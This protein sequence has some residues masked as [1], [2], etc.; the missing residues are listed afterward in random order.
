MK[1]V[2]QQIVDLIKTNIR[3]RGNGNPNPIKLGRCIKELERLYEIE[4]GSNRY[5]KIS[6]LKTQEQAKAK[7]IESG[8]L[9]GENHPNE[10]QV[11]ENI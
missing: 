10:E 1:L 2:F 9:Y 3:Q 11:Q 5:E 8:K 4:H 6:H 7:L